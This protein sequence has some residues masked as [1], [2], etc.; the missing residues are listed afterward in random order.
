VSNH[1]SVRFK[2]E[3]RASQK[4]AVDVIRAQLKQGE[5]RLHIVAPPG[6][7]KTVLGLYVW[8]EMIRRPAVVLSP[9]SAIQAQWVSQLALFDTSRANGTVSSTHPREI[10]YLTS[11]TYQ[12]VTLPS[13][14]D[15]L[16]AAAAELWRQRLLETQQA[17]DI[18]EAQAWIDD[19]RANNPAYYE[20]RLGFYR[21]TA[22]D[23][24]AT[25]GEALSTLH[26]SARQTL[27]RLRDVN[28]GLVILDECHHLLGHWGR[29]LNDAQDLLDGPLVLGLT[30]TPPDV[31]GHAPEDVQR[32]S[33][34]FGPVD[35]EVPIPALVKEKLLAPYQD[36][37]LFVR[38]TS[39]ELEFVADAD[40]RL[41]AIIEELCE[42]REDA[43]PAESAEADAPSRVE[44]LPQWISNV[45]AERR[46]PAGPVDNWTLFVRRDRALA[47]AGRRF[48][49]KR[50]LRLPEGVPP[51]SR[52]LARQEAA[53]LDVL[54]V[55]LDR[56]VRHALRRSAHQADHDLA[57]RTISELRVLGLQI[58]ETGS[59]PCASPV[60]R[61]LA[62]A[63]GKA[64]AS[65]EILKAE[66]A[67]LGESIRAV[68][69]TDYERSSAMKAATSGV[70]DAE[71]GGAIAVYRTLL[72]DPTCNE[73]DPI[74]VT[75]STVLVDADML[76]AFMDAAKRWLAQRD[77]DV[78]L[79]AQPHDS[80]TVITGEGR[81]WCPRVYV[82]MI[83]DLFQDG[84]TKCL[85][86]TRG[87]LGEG[88]DAKR[89]NVLVDLTTVTTSM[90]V[91]Q[92]RGRS[93]RLDPNDPKKLSDNWDV[94]CIAGEFTK[95]MDDYLRFLAKH[96]TLYGVT[97]D[98]EIEKGVG[99]VHAVFTTMPPE[100]LDGAAG[101]INAEMLSRA[102]RRETARR[103]WKLGQPYAGEA[104]TTMEIG[105]VTDAEQIDIPPFF[106]VKEAWSH[107]SLITA[108]ASAVLGALREAGL[109]D[110]AHH[111]QTTQRSGGVVRA[112]LRE[113]S[114]AQS[115][116]FAVSLQEVLSTED[117]PRYVIPRFVGRVQD[118]WLSRIL[119]EVLA[120]FVRKRKREFVMLHP[121]PSA[122]S[123]KKDLAIVFQRH[124]NEHVSPGEVVY[125]LHGKGE[126][127]LEKARRRGMTPMLHLQQTD[128]FA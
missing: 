67:V 31:R 116:L 1:P 66:R 47:D 101:L 115:Q 44:P 14:G 41:H 90:S 109:I 108:M 60:S 68:V 72:N 49:L 39:K 4:S 40:A 126:D 127:M 70:L 81:D 43:P 84:L 25:Q 114:E 32:Y 123:K 103:L 96:E 97:D 85:V 13:R 62:Y 125:A 11:L 63:H 22:R 92:L 26:E 102:A 8:A 12:S 77:V 105:Q 119:P 73:L 5:K 110:P 27:Q 3:L 118:T 53:E 50:G 64:L 124:W 78:V 19:L 15:D 106:G 29:V 121:V 30:A 100:D 95:G 20:Q 99:H 86:G 21:K 38:P 35:F 107:L 122:L 89:V 7:G 42:P 51:L 33:T 56:Y 58:T 18:D 16:D 6:S 28:V 52:D 82:R 37:V 111:L 59:R 65:V 88:W 76:D 34:F 79:S 54:F 24:Q 23:Q 69:I 120:R 48:L 17:D 104:V 57:R 55:V 75:G 10:A 46:L 71:A 91:N 87:L 74:L 93:L 80:F 112:F 9:N 36:L 117:R 83:T 2:G 45:L 113:A 61:I 98:G 128:V 94:V